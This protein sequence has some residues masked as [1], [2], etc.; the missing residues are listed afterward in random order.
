M[1]T[2]TVLVAAVGALVAAWATA[3]AWLVGSGAGPGP[4]GPYDAIVVLGAGVIEPGV[5]GPKLASR[6]RGAVEAAQEG[7][8]PV[9]WF[10]GGVGE[11]RV[12]S[13][14]GDVA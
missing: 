1:R 5:P 12:G 9:V 8:A 10:T 3:A 11:V 13:W 14:G 2:G 6:V 7:L 4:A